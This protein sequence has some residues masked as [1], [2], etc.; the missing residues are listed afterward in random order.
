MKENCNLVPFD[1]DKVF[2]NE[3]ENFLYYKNLNK[4]FKDVLLTEQEFLKKIFE[5]Y[6]NSVTEKHYLSQ[7]KDYE[8]FSDNEIIDCDFLKNFKNFLIENSFVQDSFKIKI[9]NVQS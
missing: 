8:Y 7:Y 4:Y 3:I 1:V 5:Y 2:L 6:A 9:K